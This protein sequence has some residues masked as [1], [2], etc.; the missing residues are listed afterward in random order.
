[1]VIGAFVALFFLGL[2]LAII[3]LFVASTL[4]RRHAR[5]P[6]SFKASPER[7]GY[8][9]QLRWRQTASCCLRPVSVVT[10]GIRRTPRADAR[11]W[12][13]GLMRRHACDA[14]ISEVNIRPYAALRRCE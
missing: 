8:C 11:P 9:D 3:G 4:D 12:S 14:A 13:Q 7:F 2:P 1:M 6:E 5:A 10:T